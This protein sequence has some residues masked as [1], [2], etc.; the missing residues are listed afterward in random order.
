MSPKVS[1]IVPIYNVE[2]YLEECL[3]SVLSQ[4]LEDIELI[5]VNDG[6]TDGSLEIIRRYEAIDARIKV[7][8]K[9]NAGYG[10]AMNAGLSLALGEYIGIVEPDD[11]IDSQMYKTMYEK[12]IESPQAD[13]VKCA[14]KEVMPDG[15]VVVRNPYQDLATSDY[16]T[17]R[18]FP[19]ILHWHPSTPM[20]IYRREFLLEHGIRYIEAPGAGWVDN[21]FFQQVFFYAKVVKLCPIPFYNYRVGDFEHSSVLRDCTVPLNRLNDMLDF[22]EDGHEDEVFLLALAK[23]AI[24]YLRRILDSPYYFDQRETVRSEITRTLRRVPAAV[25]SLPQFTYEEKKLYE[26]FS[27]PPR[28]RPACSEDAIA[29][30][31]IIPIYNVEQYLAQCLE[32]VV[33]QSLDEIEII[34]V[35]DRSRDFSRC[36]VNI[37]ADRDARIRLIAQEKNGGYGKGMNTGLVHSRGH[38]IGIVEPDD[39]IMPTM[40]AELYGHAQLYDLDVCKS[41]FYRFKEEG[42]GNLKFQYVPM[43]NNGAVYGKVFRPL[44][45]AGFFRYTMNTV[46]GVY[47]RAMLEEW[48]VRWNE[49]PGAS[50]QDNGFYVL[51]SAVANRFMFI[52]RPLYCNRRDNPNSSVADKGKVYCMNEEYELIRSWLKS[53]GFW[54]ELKEDWANLLFRNE[55]FT[56]GRIAEELRPEYVDFISKDFAKLIADEELELSRFSDAELERL[57]CIM[58]EPEEFLRVKEGSNPTKIERLEK[59]VER[60]RSSTSYKV[61]KAVTGLPRALKRALRKGE[62]AQG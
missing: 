46:T 34:C 37:F 58:S 38:Y 62:K 54:S 6:S 52:R 7:I 41:D 1:V 8:D 33:T 4:T 22:L 49:T 30:S 3:A 28:L 5:C 14:W 43:S 21:P 59:E 25:V 47:R 12:A 57:R 13:I 24:V 39:Y 32:S 51:T 23:R 60:Y 44:Q 18:S 15:E 20:G 29:V 11:F 50:F 36:I 26:Q 9:S 45:D 56:Y 48:S 61:G 55:L 17:A 19:G 40:F 31:V 10:S 42:S 16:M 35:D 53:A 2:D 27:N